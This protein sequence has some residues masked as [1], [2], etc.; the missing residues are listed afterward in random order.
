MHKRF[1]FPSPSHSIENAI[2]SRDGRAALNGF[3]KSNFAAGKIRGLDPAFKPNLFGREAEIKFAKLHAAHASGD[4]K[5]LVTALF[6]RT[7]FL[8]PPWPG[9]KRT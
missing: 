1:C 8:L 9:K 2:L 7:L 6:C 4:L 5:T 3:M